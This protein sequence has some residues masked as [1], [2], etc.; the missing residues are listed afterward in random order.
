MFGYVY[1]FRLL[2]LVKFTKGGA[3]MFWERFYSLCL[4]KGTK[5]NPVGKELG[6][7][8]SAITYWKKGSFPNAETLNKIAE[9]FNVTTSYLLG[10]SDVRHAPAPPG[11]EKS[12]AEAGLGDILPED[13][14]KFLDYYAT[15]PDEDRRVLLEHAAFLAAR[16]G[17]AVP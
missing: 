1:K 6:V 4:E 12:P 3:R 10:K 2:K 7:A 14:R 15:L 13:A 5:P 16:H 17:Q 8:S 9:Y 11:N